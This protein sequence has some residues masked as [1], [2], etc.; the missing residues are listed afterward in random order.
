MRLTGSSGG[1]LWA[2]YLRVGHGPGT[3]WLD[4]IAAGC[5]EA[6]PTRRLLATACKGKPVKIVRP[7]G[8]LH[9]DRLGMAR[10]LTGG[11]RRDDRQDSRA[12]ERARRAGKTTI[13]VIN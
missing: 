7:R 5:R 12:Q 1:E 13:N 8:A 3:T 11:A 9:V 6:S 2:R 10:S 4:L